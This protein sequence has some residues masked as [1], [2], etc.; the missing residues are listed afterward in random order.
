MASRGAASRS[1]L[2]AVRGRAASSAPRIR[3]APLPSAPRRRVPSSAFSPFAAARPMSAMMGSPAA[4]AAAGLAMVAGMASAE[5]AKAAV[6]VPVR[7]RRGAQR[8]WR[9]CPQIRASRPDLEGSWLWWLETAADLRRLATAVGDGGGVA[10]VV[11]SDG[12]GRR[13]RRTWRRHGEGR[14]QSG[15]WQWRRLVEA[16]AGGHDSGHRRHGG[17]GQLAEG[18]GD[19]CIWRARHR[20]VEGS[21]TSLAQRGAADSSGG[22]L[23]ARGAGGG[24]GGRLGARGATD[25]G[26]PA[27]R[28]RRGRR[29]RRRPRCEEELLVGVARSLAHEGWPVGDAGAGVPHVGR[30]CVV[31]EHR[32]VSR[33]SHPSRAIA[34]RKPNLGSFESRR[35]AVAV[36]PSLLFL[37]TSF[38]HPLGSDLSCVPLLV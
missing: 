31:V 36:F 3:A 11:G 28:E 19:G 9:R 8:R 24:V 32:C 26:R 33:G 21:K 17:P 37:K 18:V 10:A 14:Q 1:F 13:R 2:A 38:W 22:R 15:R 27:W 34:G 35:T 20:L 6:L 30:A 7:R 23:G 25:G 12:V 5:G 4:M 16:V 29:W